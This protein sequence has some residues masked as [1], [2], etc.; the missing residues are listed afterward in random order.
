MSDAPCVLQETSKH[1]HMFRPTPRVMGV[2]GGVSTFI[3]VP[4]NTLRSI[5]STSRKMYCAPLIW[6]GTL[7]LCLITCRFRH[8]T[9]PGNKTC[10]IIVSCSNSFTS[11]R[12]EA[13]PNSFTTSL[14]ITAGLG[15]AGNKNQKYPAEVQALTTSAGYSDRRETLAVAARFATLPE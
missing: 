10:N 4:G 8:A 13:T 14:I 12:T 3:N 6:I 7:Q 11:N 5:A 15:N 1:T 2:A 9:S